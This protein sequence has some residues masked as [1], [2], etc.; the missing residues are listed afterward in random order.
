MAG[1]RVLVADDDPQVLS[2]VEAILS[3]AGYDVL[4]S[5]N[6]EQALRAAS[7]H[8]PDLILADVMMPV[9]DGFELCRRTRLDPALRGVPFI[10]LT[11]RT[12]RDDKVYA[13]AIGARKYLT[14]PF[15]MKKLL[16]EVD[17]RLKAAGDAKALFAKKAKKFDG[18][19]SVISVFSLLD[20][21][22]IGGWT[23]TIEMKNNT[24]QTGRIEIKDAEIKKCTID[25]TED[26]GTFTQMLT[27]NEGLFCANHE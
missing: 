25:G 24:G 5:L 4:V 26:A 11:G 17:L 8:R 15:T 12:G 20:M 10:F 2:I 7:N 23:G 9:M 19:L 1:Y 16:R 3:R 27:W 13:Y 18:D 22:S 6:G 14:K 21:F